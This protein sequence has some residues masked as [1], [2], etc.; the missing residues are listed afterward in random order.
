MGS[1]HEVS[2]IHAGL[3]KVFAAL[4]L[5]SLSFLSTHAQADARFSMQA[6][7]P[8]LSGD[9]LGISL[10]GLQPDQIVTIV[11]ERR[12]AP[13]APIHMASAEMRADAQGNITL[14]GT[15]SLAG[16]YTGVDA[17]GLFWSMETSNKVDTEWQKA[18]VRLS[19]VKGEKILTQM[20]FALRSANVN[21]KTEAIA[22][23]TGAKIYLPA[24]V[25][26]DGKLPVVILLSGSEGGDAA[27]RRFGPKLAARGFAAVSY[28]YYS[29]NTPRGQEVPGLP[30][31]FIDI[32]IDGLDALY[33]TLAKRDD[34]DSKRIALMGGSKGA[35][36]ALL[37]ASLLPWVKSVVA[38]APS[39][40][41]WEG[42]AMDRLLEAG[43]YGSFS[44]QG[45]SLPFTP[46]AGLDKAFATDKPVLAHIYIE[47]RKAYP[48]R[49]K[50]AR[51]AV[52]NFKGKLLLVAGGDDQMWPSAGMASNIVASRKA[53]GLDT[54]L[55]SFPKA[56]HLVGGDGY[57]PNDYYSSPFAMGGNAREDGQA[58]TIAWPATVAFLK[59][60][61]EGGKQ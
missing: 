5:L 7:N 24:D 36:M 20:T 40:V 55:L 9:P 28:P 47:G 56:G 12:F 43:R 34:I 46:N 52:E 19:A 37:S 25:P 11:A 14:A 35:E 10:T 22:G 50:A 38:I 59:K 23:H 1:H 41:V 26:K 3:P 8:A 42:F 2:A 32:P 18:E 16:S 54:E 13:T 49:T 6:P 57:S 21:I 30:K 39:D 29:P 33:Q 44:Y 45:K 27:G 17:A 4:A 48:E 61:L 53:A 51:I 58:Q 31:D 60:S 15:A